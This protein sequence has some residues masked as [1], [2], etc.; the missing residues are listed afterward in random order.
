MFVKI[1]SEGRNI[2]FLNHRGQLFLS[3]GDRFTAESVLEHVTSVGFVEDVT[4]ADR[5]LYILAGVYS[6][7]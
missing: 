3:E 7:I 5:C 2:V 4:C 6:I 1:G